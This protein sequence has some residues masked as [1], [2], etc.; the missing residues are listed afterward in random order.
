MLGIR[1]KL[2]TIQFEGSRIPQLLKKWSAHGAMQLRV[3]GVLTMG[4]ASRVCQ[5]L[6]KRYVEVPSHKDISRRLG[7]A[8]I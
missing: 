8:A 2:P 4:Q 6:D 7:M 3:E 1:G 5:E